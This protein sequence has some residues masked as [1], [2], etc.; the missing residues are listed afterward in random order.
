MADKPIEVLLQERR[1]F[2][3]AKSF[4]KSAHVRSAQIF[5]KARKYPKALDTP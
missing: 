4:K 1:T 3:P 5:A 2:P